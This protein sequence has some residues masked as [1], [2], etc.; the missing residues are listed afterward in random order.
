MSLAAA[1][2]WSLLRSLSIALLLLPL[3]VG[4]TRLLRHSPRRQRRWIW[5]CLL[6]PFFAPDLLAG[7]AWSNFALSLVRYPVWNELLYAVLIMM[8]LA[9][10]AA[11]AIHFSPPAPVSAEA[12]HCARL[13][14]PATEGR[15]QTMSRMAGY[16]IRGPL[17]SYLPALALV[18]LLA[19]QEFEL[20]S[21]LGGTSW[22]VWLFDAQA[23]G[24]ILTDSLRYALLPLAVEVSVILPTIVLL[25][26]SRNRVGESDAPHRTPRW[27]ARTFF[28]LWMAAAAVLLCVIPLGIVGRDAGAGTAAL[29]SNRLQVVGLLREIGCGVLFGGVAG[30]ASY[31]FAALL[32]NSAA[33]RRA[34]PGGAFG[35]STAHA[36]EDHR[37]NAGGW[38]RRGAAFLAVLLAVP[39]LAGSLILA[40]CA[41]AL[42][43][44]HG[45][46]VAYDTPLP[47]FLALTLFLY[48][49]A[50][51]LGLLLL[52]ARPREPLRTAELLSAAPGAHVRSGA[53]DLVWHLE[54]RGHFWGA[55]LLCYW[56]YLDL[57]SAALLAP[58]GMVTAPVRLYNLMHYGRS[59]VL[60]S[61]TLFAVALPILLLASGAAA[62][63]RFS[64]FPVP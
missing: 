60:S 63:R 48:P 8:K 24:L 15:F 34:C 3:A 33:S 47:L 18:F 32:L 19:F 56:G 30:V 49:R 16:V 57:T 45:M 28:Y 9:P 55:A 52:A 40:L 23:G 31:T 10:V 44:S 62:W 64:R 61:M 51:L 38:R 26:K 5:I 53:R 4:L 46:H 6:A 21:L 13:V 50:L 29:L 1:C 11:V 12:L 58:S 59:D 20:A 37:H 54:R 42:F 22:T 17:R 14:V 39:G 7:Y 41:L 2:G 27:P 25:L 43:Q 35:E 36:R